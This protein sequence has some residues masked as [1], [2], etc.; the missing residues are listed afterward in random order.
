MA[1]TI[2]MWGRPPKGKVLYNE[3]MNK[4]PTYVSPLEY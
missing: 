4:N 1:I 2:R 3:Y